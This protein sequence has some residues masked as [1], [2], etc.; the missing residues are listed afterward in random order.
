MIAVN[1]SVIAANMVCV[2]A[3]IEQQHLVL[4]RPEWVSH[5]N[6][7]VCAFGDLFGKTGV[8]EKLL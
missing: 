5:K 4:L 1:A 3:V 8:H 6:C 7:P 2:L